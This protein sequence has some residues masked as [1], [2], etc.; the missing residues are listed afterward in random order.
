MTP[1][2]EVHALLETG[3]EDRQALLNAATSGRWSVASTDEMGFA[4]H[5]GEHT[6]IA[7][8]AD[9]DDAALI[10]AEHNVFEGVVAHFRRLAKEHAPTAGYVY[11]GKRYYFCG[12]CRKHFT[13]GCPD[14]RDTAK[15]AGV[16]LAGLGVA[17]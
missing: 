9:R 4:V 10:V 16:D 3:I 2:E 14:Y 15:F 17:G 6:T 11:E 12:R 7:L 5:Q 1:Q 13:G 8:Y